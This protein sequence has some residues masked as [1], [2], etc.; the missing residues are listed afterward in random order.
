MPNIQVHLKFHWDEQNIYAKKS[1]MDYKFLESI[2]LFLYYHVILQ[3]FKGLK[4][5]LTFS[6][7][8]EPTANPLFLPLDVLLCFKI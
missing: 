3:N 7:E 1:R 5:I 4:E 2:I 6:G 8:G